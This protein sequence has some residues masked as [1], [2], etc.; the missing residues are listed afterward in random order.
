MHSIHL[1]TSRLSLRPFSLVDVDELHRL[2][3]EPAVRRFLWDDKVVPRETVIEII[4][5]SNESFTRS[6]L[7]YWVVCL[8][9]TSEAV[10]FCGLRHFRFEEAAA[11]ADEVEILYGLWPAHWGKGL[12][13]DASAAVLR[14]GFDALG[15]T[16]IYAGADPP[17][18]D[19][20]RVMERLGMKFLRRTTVGELEAV[21]YV[22]C[23]DEFYTSDVIG[24]PEFQRQI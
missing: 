18:Q 7:G 10:G 1:E 22:I 3:S 11:G 19:S 8:K 12:A 15:L 21:Y 20:F 4:K 2:W 24:H 5:S 9:E 14:Y 17:N 23:R 16:R 13:T 6:G